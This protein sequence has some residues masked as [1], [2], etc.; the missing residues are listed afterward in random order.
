MGEDVG[1]PNPR[2]A[3]LQTG[4]GLLAFRNGDWKLRFT[5]RPEWTGEDVKFLEAP[6]ELYNLADDPFEVNDLAE[7]MPERVT[8]MES[9]LM[10]L[11]EKGRSR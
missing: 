8:K 10:V 6:Y 3:I 2:T 9:H 5:E 4:H 11:I 7:K 1:D